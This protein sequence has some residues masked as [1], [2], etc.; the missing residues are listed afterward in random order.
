MIENVPDVAPDASAS[1]VVETVSVL[2]VV[3]AC[4]TE[5]VRVS[6][7]PVT[8]T[9]PVRLVLPVFAV[10]L[11]VKLP[12]LLPLVGEALSQVWSSVTVQLTFAVTLTADEDAAEASDSAVCDSVRLLAVGAACVT[13]I[14]RVRPPPVTVTVP[15]RAAVPVFAVALTVKLPLLVPLSWRGGD[16]RLVVRDRPARHSP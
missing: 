9:V 12:L 5:T 7:P 6:P 1:D 2:A 15:V 8:V 11:T 13:A 14:V 4:V 10:A 3:P 16:P